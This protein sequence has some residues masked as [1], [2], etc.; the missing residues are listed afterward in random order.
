MGVK[1]VI[2]EPEPP[3][4]WQQHRTKVIATTALLAGYWLGSTIA[5]P[6]D[7]RPEPNPTPTTGTPAE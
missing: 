1:Y 7:A 4:W 6:A 3:T 2:A 5:P